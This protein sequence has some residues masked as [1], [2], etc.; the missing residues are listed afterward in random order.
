MD[1]RPAQEKRQRRRRTKFSDQQLARLEEIFQKDPF[2]GI[3]LREKLARELGLEHCII[4]F[5]LK[6]LD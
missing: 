6:C 4:Q 1:S 3:Y 2:P 5:P